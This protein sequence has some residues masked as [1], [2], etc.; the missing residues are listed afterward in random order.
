MGN[1][2]SSLRRRVVAETHSAGEKLNVFGELSDVLELMGLLSGVGHQH[3]TSKKKK[4]KALE[5][6][7]TQRPDVRKNLL[8][9]S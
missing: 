4:E 8:S 3:I 1:P 7:G 2:P 9:V 6:F 5:E